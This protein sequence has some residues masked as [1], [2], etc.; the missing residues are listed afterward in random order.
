MNAHAHIPASGADTR[1]A[2][3]SLAKTQRRLAH[4]QRTAM[5]QAERDGDLKAYRTAKAEQARLWAEAKWHLQ[6][7]RRQTWLV[8]AEVERTA[9]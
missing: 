6:F 5:D 2:L 9:S 4:H 3:L 1:A 8:V 7:A